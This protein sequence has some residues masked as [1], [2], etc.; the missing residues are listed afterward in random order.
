MAPQLALVARDWGGAQPLIGRLS[1]TDTLRLSR[2]S[3]M[4]VGRLRLFDGIVAPF[5]QAGVGQWRV[6]TDVLPVLPRDVELA[7]Q[8][9]GGLEFSADA[10]STIGL[11]ADYTILYREQHEPQMISGPHLWGTYLA[12]RVLF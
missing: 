12:A 3:R 4:V 2:S 5:A 7:G 6:D 11:E 9:G 1:V 10:N 8:L